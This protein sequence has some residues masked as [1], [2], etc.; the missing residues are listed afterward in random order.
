MESS[1]VEQ[2]WLADIS[3]VLSKAYLMNVKPGD[4]FHLP[5]AG[6]DRIRSRRSMAA[7]R[8]PEPVQLGL[9][10]DRNPDLRTTHAVSE[11]RAVVIPKPGI[12]MKRPNVLLPSGANQTECYLLVPDA[13][14]VGQLELSE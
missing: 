13:F 11:P 3:A 14:F 7:R 5:R 6:L 8:Q 9:H 10:A 4:E 2:D 12:T 1:I